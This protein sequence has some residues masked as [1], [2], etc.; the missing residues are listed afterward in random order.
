MGRNGKRDVEQPL[1]ALPT[2]S[3]G[4]AKGLSICYGTAWPLDLPS[5]ATLSAVGKLQQTH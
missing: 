2:A 1:G 5:S 3:G 4:S